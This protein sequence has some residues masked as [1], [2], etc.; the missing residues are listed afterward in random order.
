M[1]ARFFSLSCLL[2]L[3]SVLSGCGDEERPASTPE[4]APVVSEEPPAPT[5]PEP[6]AEPPPLREAREIRIPSEGATLV[7]DLRV[8]DSVAAPLVVL[9]HQL[10]STRAEWEPLLRHLGADPAL[11]TFALDMRGHG[12]STERASTE[13][14]RGAALDWQ[15]FETRD[16]EAVAADLRAVLGH[17]REEEGLQP[18]RVALIGSSIGSSA[19]IRAAS[20]DESVDV[21]V[22]LSPGRAYRGLDAITPLPALGER[23]FLAVAS[24]GEAPSAE[25]AQD[26]ARIAGGGELLLVE[27]DAHGVGMFESAPDSLPRVATFL[28]THLAAAE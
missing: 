6:P 3:V 8:G 28:R 22:A 14:E 2:G 17:L 12:A 9:V 7:G 27:G 1:N 26:M 4:P 13:R 15:R 25:A 10:S 19:V 23:P 11:S 21:V 16:W 18:T 24:R 20:E 5:E